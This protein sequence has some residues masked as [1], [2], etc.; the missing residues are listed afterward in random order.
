MG[1]RLIGSVGLAPGSDEGTD[2]T[3]KGDI[4]GY[5]TS[6]TRIPV[7]VN[8]TVLTADSTEA[9]GVKWASVSGSWVSTATSNLDMDTYNIFDIDFLQLSAPTEV[10]ISSN[11]VTFSQSFNSIDGESDA[12]DDLDYWN[13]VTTGQFLI[14]KSENNAR[15]ITLRSGVTGDKKLNATGNYTLADVDY[16]FTA[17]ADTTIANF[18]VYELSRSSNSA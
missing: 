17:L 10:T 2:L 6:N 4:H 3:T 1:K 14:L 7:G 15:D 16:R 18:V 9:L 11:A 5:S 13:G 8:D 12:N